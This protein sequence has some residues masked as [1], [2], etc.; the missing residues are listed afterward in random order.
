MLKPRVPVKSKGQPRPFQKQARRLR[1]DP[2]ARAQGAPGQPRRASTRRDD[3]EIE[4]G[5]GASASRDARIARD[6]ARAIER[7][8]IA[9]VVCVRAS[10]W[11]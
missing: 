5:R 10:K 3:A 11:G 9:T 2:P 8:D 1:G 7:D 6:A 4:T